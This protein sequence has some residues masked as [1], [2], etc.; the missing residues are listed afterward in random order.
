M[1]TRFRTQ[2]RTVLRSEGPSYQTHGSD[3]EADPENLLYEELAAGTRT[4]G[5]LHLFFKDLC[6]IVP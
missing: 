2:S 6:E 1:R 4:V 5:R 3:N